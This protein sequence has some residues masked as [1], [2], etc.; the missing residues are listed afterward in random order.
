MARIV[1]QVVI[2]DRIHEPVK[3]IVLLAL[4]ETT[5]G[6]AEQQDY[7][8]NSNHPYPHYSSFFQNCFGIPFD[9]AAQ[10]ITCCGLGL[11]SFQQPAQSIQ[12]LVGPHRLQ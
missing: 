7:S 2:E 9:L 8:V 10:L 5:R 11:E 12:H 3:V 4:S 6:N 1:L